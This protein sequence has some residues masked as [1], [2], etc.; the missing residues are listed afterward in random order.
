MFG[1]LTLCAIIILIMISLVA[2]QAEAWDTGD[3]DDDTVPTTCLK[4]RAQNLNISLKTSRLDE[5]RSQALDRLTKL[6]LQV[7][8]LEHSTTT[9]EAEDDALV[10]QIDALNIDTAALDKTIRALA[11]TIKVRVDLI[12]Q[13]QALNARIP[14]SQ[15]RRDLAQLPAIPVV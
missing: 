2:K 1:L 4:I 12:A 8:E 5:T 9:L 11:A 15:V 13:Y 14:M 10:K 3:D 7:I 6:K